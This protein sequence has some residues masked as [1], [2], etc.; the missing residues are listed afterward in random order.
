MTLVATTLRERLFRLLAILPAAILPLPP[1]TFTTVPEDVQL[2]PLL[3]RGIARIRLRLLPDLGRPL[4][5]HPPARLV[6]TT[7]G[8]RLSTF[9]TIAA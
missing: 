5:I 2:L 8:R 1:G 7:N 6:T 9:L 3:L 4:V